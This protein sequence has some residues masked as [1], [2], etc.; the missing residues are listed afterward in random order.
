MGRCKGRTDSSARRSLGKRAPDAENYEEVNED[1]NPTGQRM[2]WSGFGILVAW[3]YG[4]FVL[5]ECFLA[6]WGKLRQRVLGDG[7]GKR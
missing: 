5:V 2:D 7:T 3:A 6:G 4:G 1:Y